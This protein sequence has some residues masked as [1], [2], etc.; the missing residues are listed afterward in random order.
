MKKKIYVQQGIVVLVTHVASDF[1]TITPGEA[2]S[3]AQ[4]YEVPVDQL[5]D[6]GWQYVDESH[7]PAFIAPAPVP[8][9]IGPNQFYF[10]W[11]GAELDAIDEIRVTDKQVNRFMQRLE[12][13]RTTEVVLSDPAI[14][15]GIRLTVAQLVAKGVI[16]QADADDRVAT[17]IAGG[18]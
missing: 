12:D 14:Q 7:L 1:A 5:V 3:G 18:N 13:P 10:L 17:I 16:K 6:I 9:T 4:C 15:G 2:A 11:S 8:P